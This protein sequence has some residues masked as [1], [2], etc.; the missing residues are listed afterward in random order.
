MASEPRY[1]YE[2]GRYPWSRRR[3]LTWE[4]WALDIG[5]LAC[6]LA[7]SPYV[8]ELAHPWRS[9]G[10]VFAVFAL[11]VVIARWKTEPNDRD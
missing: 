4:G 6:V 2:A 7:I 8:S 11:Y 9:L 10:L 1:W 5:L 3:P